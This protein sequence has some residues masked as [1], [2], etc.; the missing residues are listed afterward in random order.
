M[1]KGETKAELENHIKTVH[2]D[3]NPEGSVSESEGS[4]SSQSITSSAESRGRANAVRSQF[5][6][7]VKTS[8]T[9]KQGRKYIEVGAGGGSTNVPE[10]SRH[11]LKS[12]IVQKPVAKK[13][14]KA[15]KMITPGSQVDDENKK[16]STEEVAIKQSGVLQY[17]KED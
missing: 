12:E 15:K 16:S 1:G 14:S 2:E 8:K 9:G 10:S 5:Q 7:I 13:T 3:L 4:V 6:Y 11:E 17:M